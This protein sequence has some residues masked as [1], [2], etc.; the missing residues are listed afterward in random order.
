M[1]P[2][3]AI[4]LFI[5]YDQEL[6]EVIGDALQFEGHA[7]VLADPRKGILPLSQL[8]EFDLVIADIASSHRAGVDCLTSIRAANED[9]PIIAISIRHQLGEDT[10][11]RERLRRAGADFVLDR[12]LSLDL[13]L[14]MIDQTIDDTHAQRT[15]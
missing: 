10:E 14:A 1:E 8:D 12:D 2:Y 9:I 15:N 6:S 7:V 5:E 4:I 13:L 3:R 11:V